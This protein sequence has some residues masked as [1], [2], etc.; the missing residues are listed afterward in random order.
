MT[1]TIKNASDIAGMRIAGA[2]AADV[3]RMIEPE[4]AP[5]VS[6]GQLDRL[7]HDYIVNQQQAIPA[8]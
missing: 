1:V 4:V 2:L 5:G 7:C 6:T 8:P 3:L